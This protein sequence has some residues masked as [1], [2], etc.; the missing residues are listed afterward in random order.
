MKLADYLALHSKTAEEFAREVRATPVSIRR[1]LGGKR[2]PRL[3]VL[4]RIIAAT[5]GAVTANDFWE[6]KEEDGASPDVELCVTGRAMTDERALKKVGDRIRRAREKVGLTQVAL[7]KRIGVSRGAISNWEQGV[8]SIRNGKLPALAAALNLHPSELTPFGDYQRADATPD[9]AALVRI[10][11]KLDRLLDDLQV[12][13]KQQES[14]ATRLNR[15]E[16]R[17][18]RIERRGLTNV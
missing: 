3:A 12:L 9:Q 18:E 16:A 11:E 10:E 2:R 15:I 6:P 17:L 14:V 5:G 1:Y 13:E 8:T 4:K 7:A